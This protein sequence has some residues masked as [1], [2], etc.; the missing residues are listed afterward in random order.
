MIN[1][2]L[3]EFGIKP[4]EITP[5]EG[6]TVWT[7]DNKYVL[8]E[9]TIQNIMKSA[10][11]TE[12]LINAGV[13]VPAYLKTIDG[14]Y[15]FETDGKYYAL[16]EKVQGSHVDL[17]EEH[18]QR[19]GSDFGFAMA[20]LHNALKTITIENAHNVDF[21]KEL[22][23]W[24]IPEMSN[25]DVNF[26]DEVMPAC[27]SWLPSYHALPRQLIHRDMH[28]GNFLFNGS[29]FTGFIDFDLSQINAKIFDICYLGCTLLMEK[30]EDKELC[31]KW[32]DIFSDILNGYNKLCPLTKEELSAM[33]MMF[34]AIEIIFTAWFYKAGEKEVAHNC[35]KFVNWLYCNQ[36]ILGQACSR[37]AAAP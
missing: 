5:F 18:P 12:L 29:K 37:I 34:V 22:Y 17:F 32:Q 26:M 3:K 10:E 9:S 24:I 15:M 6:H 2:I 36:D 31:S 21:E 8:K 30:Y 28:P 27:Y 35:V 23:D 4:A 25:A 7:V 16:M 14:S 33:P 1:N 11:L 19:L 13:P 20:K